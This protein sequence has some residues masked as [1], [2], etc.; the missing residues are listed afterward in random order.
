MGPPYYKRRNQQLYTRGL[1]QISID[2][3]VKFIFSSSRMIEVVGRIAAIIN[4]YEVNTVKEE[5][6]N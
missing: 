4:W 1:I 5:K 2:C 6:K 3:D